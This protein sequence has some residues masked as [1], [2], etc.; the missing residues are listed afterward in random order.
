MTSSA[1]AWACVHR[2]PKAGVTE[3]LLPTSLVSALFSPPPPSCLPPFT[4]LPPADAFPSQSFLLIYP[5]LCPI[6]APLTERWAGG[7]HRQEAERGTGHWEVW[8]GEGVAGG[9]GNG[10]DPETGKGGGYLEEPPP[11]WGG[12]EQQDDWGGAWH[13][14]DRDRRPRASRGD[15]QN[16]LLLLI[17]ILSPQTHKPHAHTVPSQTLSPSHC[18]PHHP[19]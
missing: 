14:Q 17:S 10:E 7:G 13:R 12:Q 18:L 19:P 8:G 4:L 5:S 3:S 16:E 9:A 15:A 1:R 6:I 11:T 2:G